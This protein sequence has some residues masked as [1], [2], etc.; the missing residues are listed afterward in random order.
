MD[1]LGV[2]RREKLQCLRQKLSVAKLGLYLVPTLPLL[3]LFSYGL[4]IIF[5]VEITAIVR[6]IT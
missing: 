5:E 6:C 2:E 1:F 4:K 3:Y